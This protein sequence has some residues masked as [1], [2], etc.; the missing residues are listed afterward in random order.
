MK[1][2]LFYGL[3]FVV[4]FLGV[5]I[6]LFQIG[7][8]RSFQFFGEIYPRVETSNKVVALTFDDGPTK[9]HTDEILQIL[10]EEDVK[11]TFY[12]IG[13][14]I[15]A[16]PG[17]T[18]KI[19]AAGHEIGNHSYHHDRMWLV[20]PDFVKNEIENTDGLIRKAGFKGEITFRPPFGKKLFVLPWYLSSHNRK[21]ITWDVEPNT[22]FQKTDD[23]TKNAL[24]N[25]K[26]G[27][28]ILLHVMYDNVADSMN[29][30]RPIIK[31]LKDKGFEFKTVSE[32]IA[33][34]S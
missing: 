20:T 11:A 16:N 22:Y 18:E 26:N 34:K 4:L 13:A 3:G 1:K 9:A 5:A 8:S 30:V 28:I 2:K 27:S 19:I 17:E 6:S 31:G 29:S 23:L 21:S 33:L 12:L 24:E 25:T 10:Q 14:E 32:L 15:E 7:K